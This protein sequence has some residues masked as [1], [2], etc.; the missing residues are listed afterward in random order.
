M[1]TRTCARCSRDFVT[2]GSDAT[3]CGLCVDAV[4]DKDVSA[5]LVRGMLDAGA[6]DEEDALAQRLRECIPSKYLNPQFERDDTL[7]MIA[8]S[9]MMSQFAQVVNTL[10]LMVNVDNEGLR[11]VFRYFRV[12]LDNLPTV[13]QLVD[14]T[15][16]H[17]AN[18]QVDLVSVSSLFQN[19]SARERWVDTTFGLEHGG[20]SNDGQE[21]VADEPVAKRPRLDA[22]ARE[23]P[24]RDSNAGTDVE[25]PT[26]VS[27]REPPG[28]DHARRL[29]KGLAHPKFAHTHAFQVKTIAVR[30]KK[31]APEDP[32]N[33]VNTY[34]PRIAKEL[35]SIDALIAEME[36]DESVTPEVW[37]LFVDNIN[38]CKNALC[39]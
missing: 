7:K 33:Q 28:A 5:V 38:E 34:F 20:G 6:V 22:S 1:A 31:L 24:G 14:T 16:D 29:L 13:N 3:A 15:D 27:T 32:L 25:T 35:S 18:L 19:G 2:D 23:A 26:P 9:I 36:A 11:A 12:H 39:E 4:A 37:T 30:V 17:S 21:G 10:K 8:H